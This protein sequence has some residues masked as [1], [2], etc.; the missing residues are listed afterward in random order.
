M[1]AT[2]TCSVD[3]FGCVQSQSA[4]AQKPALPSA[5]SSVYAELD[6][7]RTSRSYRVF[8]SRLLLN[9]V[10]RATT[11]SLALLTVLRPEGLMG[12]AG[13]GRRANL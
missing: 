13:A 7:V 6:D 1:L 10:E 11:V 3:L 12:V 8:R 5:Y 4:D 2:D 9:T